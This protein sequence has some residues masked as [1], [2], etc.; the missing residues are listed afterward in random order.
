MSPKIGPKLPTCPIGIPAGLISIGQMSWIILT[1]R[2][3]DHLVD[4][5]RSLCCPLFCCHWVIA[6]DVL[7]QGMLDVL[8]VAPAIWISVLEPYI[9]IVCSHVN[10]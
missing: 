10:K 1:R 2:V 9:R 7:A 5:G 8:H 4:D 3:I 6:D